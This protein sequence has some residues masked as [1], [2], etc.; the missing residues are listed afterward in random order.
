MRKIILSVIIISMLTI[1][2]TACGGSGG[3]TTNTN[4]SANSGKPGDGV[5]ILWANYGSSQMPPN[6]AH[7]DTIKYL[8]ENGFT[9]DYQPD[10]VLGG[11]SDTMQQLMDGTVQM[12]DLTTATLSLYSNIGDVFQ[13][14]FLIGDYSVE[15][16][17]LESDEAFAIY[18]KIGDSI[19]IK[20]LPG[21]LENGIR[22]FATNGHPIKTVADLKGVKLRIA[23][24]SLLEQAMK[25]LGASPVSVPY[26][27][28]YNSL[29]NH[30]IDGEEINITSIY[31]LKHY[32]QLEYISK[33]GMYPFP[34]FVGVN[35][36]WW[37]T[38]SEEAQN[39]IIEGLK[40]G[41]E[42]EFST[43]LPEYETEAENAIIASGTQIN[44]IEGDAR[45]E[46]VD[47]CKPLWDSER[48]LDELCD[49]FINKAIEVNKAHGI[50]V[51]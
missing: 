10:A 13:T 5:T 16:E 42:A 25:D 21:I 22:H 8:E 45:Q 3:E 4:T 26:N 24:N 15:K 20:I 7:Q 29:Q 33:I 44:T 49:A 2:L 30:V 51:E 18:D 38:L 14:P 32:E 1:A 50:N 17:V 31:A 11:E 9:I 19:G 12:A 6:S 35:L 34:Q 37:N 48:Q 23:N 36:E 43:Y 40:Q 27:D 41:S 39:T 46:F 28:V 47:I